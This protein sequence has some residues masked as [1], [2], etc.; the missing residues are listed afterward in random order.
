MTHWLRNTIKDK[1]IEW[2]ND[3]ITS[4]D[5]MEWALEEWLPME[6]TYEDLEKELIIRG[7]SI[8]RDILELIENIEWNFVTKDDIEILLE[9]LNTP[10]GQYMTGNEK[11][12][13][14][15]ERINWSTRKEMLRNVPPY[16]LD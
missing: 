5:I 13:K 2:R 9:Y 15:F 4:S 8:C 3:T 7:E 6:D 14:H 12:T 11:L 16:T 1:L 10:I